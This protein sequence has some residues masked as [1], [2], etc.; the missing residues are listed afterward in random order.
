[1]S[2]HEVRDILIH[3]IRTGYIDQSDDQY[4]TISVTPKANAVLFE[5]E[6]VMMRTQDARHA[7]AAKPHKPAVNT[8]L[9]AKLKELR[10]ALAQKQSVPA[11]VIFSDAA[12]TDMCA[13]LPKS[14]EAFLQ[15]SGVGNKKLEQYGAAFL[16]VISSFKNEDMPPEQPSNEQGLFHAEDFIKQEALPVSH[17]LDPVNAFLL[18]RGA[19]PVA[20]VKLTNRLLQEGYLELRPFEGKDARVPSE[21]GRELGIESVRIDRPGGSGYLQNLYGPQAQRLLAGWAAEMAE[22]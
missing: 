5:G 13:R 21:K 6:R 15:V 4:S 9:L 22:P 3:L 18:Q 20:A 14:P 8:A 1:M 7:P 10:T 16:E 2:Q 11:F 12:L 17:F 19:A